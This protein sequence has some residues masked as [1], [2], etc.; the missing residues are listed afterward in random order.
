MCAYEKSTV[1]CVAED[2]L[3]DKSNCEY[4]QKISSPSFYRIQNGVK[5]E[6]KTSAY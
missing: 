2:D 6:K 3:W 1:S 5:I 4:A